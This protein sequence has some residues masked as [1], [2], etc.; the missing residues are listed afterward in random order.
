MDELL[1]TLNLMLEGLKAMAPPG[2]VLAIQD[3]A[4]DVVVPYKVVF[5]CDGRIRHMHYHCCLRPG[6][7]G[8]CYTDNKKMYFNKDN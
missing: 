3:A 8:Q 5:L 4:E 7:E 2:T 1:K 6:H